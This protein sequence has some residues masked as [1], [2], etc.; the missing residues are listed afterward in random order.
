M[1]KMV[2]KIFV[3]KSY[4]MFQSI[5]SSFLI[6]VHQNIFL[7]EEKKSYLGLKLLHVLAEVS[8]KMTSWTQEN[9]SKKLTE[10]K[11]SLMNAAEFFNQFSQQ[12][13]ILFFEKEFWKE[14]ESK[15]NFAKVLTHLKKVS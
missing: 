5:L 10:I 14:A 15:M 6:E 4:E 3:V 12:E 7:F 1:F 9:Y 2:Q 8:S 13:D 11:D